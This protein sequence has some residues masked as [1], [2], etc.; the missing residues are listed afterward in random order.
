MKKCYKSLIIKQAQK[1][2]F[3]SCKSKREL[4][5]CTILLQGN[6]FD[7]GWFN[8][9]NQRWFFTTKKEKQS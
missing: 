5:A 8:P 3:Y 7:E 4:L 1:R 2:G 6:F 9:L